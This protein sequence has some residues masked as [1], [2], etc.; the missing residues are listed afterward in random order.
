MSRGEIVVRR[1]PTVCPGR[2][3]RSELGPRPCAP[4]P[5]PAEL[6]TVVVVD[7]SPAADCGLPF[8]SVVVAPATVVVERVA[9]AVVVTAAPAPAE[10]VVVVV[11][12]TDEADGAELACPP[13]VVFE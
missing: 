6:M 9:V 1:P 7:G 8:A 5:A 13:E 3:V 4:P 11:V 10:M 2:V 12:A